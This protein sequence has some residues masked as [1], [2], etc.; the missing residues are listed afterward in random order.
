MKRIL[1]LLLVFV[2]VFALAACGDKPEPTEPTG[3]S[4]PTA[5]T[6]EGKTLQIWAVVGNEYETEDK[7]N[8]SVWLWMVRAAIVEW[9]HI[10]KVNLQFVSNFDQTSLMAAITSGSKPDLVFTS[11]QFPSAANLGLLQELTDD[12]AAK[13]AE[14]IGDSWFLT[15]RGGKYGIQSPWCGAAMVYYNETMMDNYGV[16]TPKEYIEEGNW[17]WENFMK[18]AK[19]CTRDIDSDGKIDTWGSTTYAIGG[20]WSA[21][22]TVDP[23]TGKLSNNMESD[24][25]KDWLDIYFDAV[26]GDEPYITNQYKHANRAGSG[27]AMSI[28]DCEPYNFYHTY[29]VLEN[30]DVIRAVQKPTRDGSAAGSWP[31]TTWQFAIPKNSDEAD[32]AVDLICYIAKAGMKWME[33]HSEGVFET[34]FEGI[35]GACDYSAAWLEKYNAF[36]EERH[37]RYTQIAEDWDVEFNKTMMEAYKTAKK[38]FGGSY[39]GVS[40]PWQG[41]GNFNS[42]FAEAP[43]SSLPKLSAA[44]K[45]MLDT[46]NTKYVF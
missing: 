41:A 28:S 15:H 25:V 33:D 46:Y 14:V 9:A 13:I 18:I 2:M 32:A 42:I 29:Q 3:P 45:A 27:I 39:A 44:M 12:Q 31:T 23:V 36:L 8:A 11:G 40:S 21:A 16:K 17:T 1:A 10:N 20:G 37:E 26:A 24:E 4:E 6:L 19:E 38:E 30:G 5:E 7:I 22:W 34:E 35:T 43:A